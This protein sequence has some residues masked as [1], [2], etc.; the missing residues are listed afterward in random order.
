MPDD[1]VVSSDTEAKGGLFPPHCH[2]T[3]SGLCVLKNL[4][5]W[6]N[7][8]EGGAREEWNGKGKSSTDPEEVLA[9]GRDAA[10]IQQGADEARQEAAKIEPCDYC[11]WR[12]K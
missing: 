4:Q 11:P 10:H 3:E 8:Y 6:G 2:Q 9:V 12:R 1:T 5:E 7:F